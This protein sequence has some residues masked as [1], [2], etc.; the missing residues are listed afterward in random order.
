MSIVGYIN[1]ISLITTDFD[2]NN[3]LYYIDIILYVRSNF[4]NSIREPVAAVC[5]WA[6]V[7]SSDLM[8]YSL[9]FLKY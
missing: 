5:F 6:V 9:D 7:N 3:K 1:D 2:N 4:Y 8:V